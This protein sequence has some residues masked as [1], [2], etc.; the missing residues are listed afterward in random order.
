[1]RDEYL[2]PFWAEHHG[3]WTDFIGGAIRRAAALPA[4]I[5][6]RTRR[7]DADRLP[8]RHKEA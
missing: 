3:L 5:G 8:A 6:Q 7:K 1:M 4:H 2:A